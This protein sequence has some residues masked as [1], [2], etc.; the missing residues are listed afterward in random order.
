MTTSVWTRLSIASLYSWDRDSRRTSTKT[1]RLWCS[2]MNYDEPICL[3]DGH[4][5]QKVVY[6]Y[7]YDENFCVSSVHTAKQIMAWVAFNIGYCK[8]A[9]VFFFLLISIFIYWMDY[10]MKNE[11]SEFKL[12]LLMVLRWK[13]C[14]S[15]LS[16]IQVSVV[17]LCMWMKKLR[18]LSLIITRNLYRFSLNLVSR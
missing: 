8:I 9:N 16:G 14:I 15:L 5:R 10:C 6:L 13:F 17:T 3:M 18:F 7:F 1:H 4:S 12:S 2:T 11:Y